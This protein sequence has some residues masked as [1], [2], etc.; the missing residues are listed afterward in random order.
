VPKASLIWSSVLP[1][2]SFVSHRTSGFYFPH[3][4]AAL[5]ECLWMNVD[6]WDNVVQTIAATHKPKTLVG[7][8]SITFR[9]L[10]HLAFSTKSRSDHLAEL[11]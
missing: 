7:Y 4:D 11:Q 9:A 10:V 3:G 1:M 5:I 2:A 6:T 8:M